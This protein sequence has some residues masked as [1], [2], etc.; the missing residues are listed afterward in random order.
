[1]L[2][3]WKQLYMIMGLYTNASTVTISRFRFA[4]TLDT[5]ERFFKKKRKKRQCQIHRTARV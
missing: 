1:M 4:Y 3:C 5:I 2:Q